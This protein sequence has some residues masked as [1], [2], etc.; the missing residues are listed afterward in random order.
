M[1]LRFLFARRL[2]VTATC[3]VLLAVCATCASA[4]W[5]QEGKTEAET[6]RDYKQCY[7]QTQ[8]RYGTDLESPHFKTDLAQCMES[9]GYRRK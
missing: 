1:T 8:Q 9:R 4:E 2:T 5:V 6:H 3:M 7:A